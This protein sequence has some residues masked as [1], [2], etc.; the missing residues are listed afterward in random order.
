MTDRAGT[1]SGVAA[2]TI[3]GLLLYFNE[4]VLN[5]SAVSSISLGWM[6]IFASCV[7]LPGRSFCCCSQRVIYSGFWVK[8]CRFVYWFGKFSVRVRVLFYTR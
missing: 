5:T 3:A 8:C 1:E 6:L 7:I 2:A 4:I